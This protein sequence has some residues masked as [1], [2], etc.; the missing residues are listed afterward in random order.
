MSTH[1]NRDIEWTIGTWS[2]KGR[3][4][5]KNKSG[6]TWIQQGHYIGTLGIEKRDAATREK[7]EG[8]NGDAIWGQYPRAK[9]PLHSGT[10]YWDGN[11]QLGRH[12]GTRPIALL[13]GT[14]LIWWWPRIWNSI[15]LSM[16]GATP[17]MVI[18]RDRSI[19]PL[20]NPDVWPRSPAS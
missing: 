16:E 15:S 9:L 19:L 2:R 3:D 14:Y 20:L 4:T 7:D 6:H 1:T 17:P 10:R 8:D 5:E 18:S 11:S 13:M 12:F